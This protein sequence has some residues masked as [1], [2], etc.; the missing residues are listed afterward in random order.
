MFMRRKTSIDF[1]N[2]TH[3]A[4]VPWNHDRQT[5]EHKPELSP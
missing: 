1:S 5:K 2:Y 4:A 3:K